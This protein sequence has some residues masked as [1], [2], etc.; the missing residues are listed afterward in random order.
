M[1]NSRS[2]M[3]AI[4]DWISREQY[5]EKAQKLRLEVEKAFI[6]HP[7]SAGET[8][9]EHMAFTMRMAG[10][11]FYASSAIVV[12]GVFP[13]LCTR[14]ASTQ[15]EQLYRIMKT[16]I[17]KQRRE[18]IDKEIRLPLRV[19]SASGEARVAIIGGGFSG[20][21]AFANLV[22]RASGP[23]AIEWF[24]PAVPGEGLAYGTRQDV[25]LLNVRADRMGAFAGEADGF[26][27]WLQTDVGAKAAAVHC[28][29]LA[30]APELFL[31]RA[32]YAVYLRQIVE[33][34]KALAR[35]KGI[36]LRITQAEVHDVLVHDAETQQLMVEM[37]RGGL[38][39]EVLVDAAVL[40]TGN[41]PPRRF[42]FQASLM[43]GAKTYIEDGWKAPAGHI[44]PDKVAESPADA[45]IVVIGTGLTM[46]DTVLT[47]KAKGFRGM[48]T[49]ISRH[50][51]MPAPHGPA[52][53]YP[54]WDWVMA[55]Q[56]APR[57]TLGLLVRLREEIRR[58][59][60]QGYDWRAV[61]DSLRPVTQT[62]W[63]QLDTTQRRKFMARLFTMW[64]VHRHRMAPQIHQ[65]LKDLQQSG[66]LKV[67]AGKIYYAGT[68]KDGITVSFRKRG[69]NRMESLRPALV[70]N[71]TGPE[72]D[73]AAAEHALL[74]RLRDRELITVG[75]LRM[76]IE[77][78]RDGA[79]K[80]KAGD[81]LFPLGSLVV[82]ELLECT[83]VPELR[84]QANDTAGR[85]LER[86]RGLYDQ[87]EHMR[88]SMGE[89]I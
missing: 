37:E 10:R 35:D 67:L 86:L 1:T 40:A 3:K 87:E 42:D 22:K 38:K 75:P 4:S 61:V 12:H 50:G 76:G 73:I 9:F 89:W 29:G 72:Y 52:K 24:E 78:T 43:V 33:D 80:G 25:H 68:D 47:L 49:A 69:S 54:D 51:L 30:L 6:D 79:A 53:P 21:M 44:F 36:K 13:F 18:E 20:A 62:L 15:I 66:A 16:R 71:C 8:Y 23:L 14:T 83:A 7:Q 41:L 70:I 63:G 28:P 65:Q 34:A 59:E 2:P 5:K 64:N 85:V 32:L 17:P 46:V 31:P 55:P 60:A 88:K 19:A 45:E 27:N 11:F 57:T 77:I 56:F 48:I 81:A 74:R 84:Q 82:G 58:A 26:W 39:Q